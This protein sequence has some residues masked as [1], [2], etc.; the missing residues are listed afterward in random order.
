MGVHYGWGLYN[1]EMCRGTQCV[2]G[3]CCRRLEED[4]LNWGRGVRAARI[5][6]SINELIIVLYKN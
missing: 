3:S 2:G 1:G 5:N 4:V 6:Y